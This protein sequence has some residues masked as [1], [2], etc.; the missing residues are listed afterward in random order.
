[1]VEVDLVVR[2]VEREVPKEAAE[3]VVEARL[4]AAR[5]VGVTDEVVVGRVLAEEAMELVEAVMAAVVAQA[6]EVKVTLVATAEE[7]EETDCIPIPAQAA[8]L[9]NSSRDR[10]GP[11]STSDLPIAPSA[12]TSPRLET[13]R[14]PG[15][16]R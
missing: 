6:V 9:Q 16:T 13:P 1:M 14:W 7:E 12:P 15:A 8:P 4:E 5:V 10:S 3:A 11:G 2:V